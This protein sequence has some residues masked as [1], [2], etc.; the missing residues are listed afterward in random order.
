MIRRVVNG[1]HS[2]GTRKC[3]AVRD[4]VTKKV[5]MFYAVRDGKYRVCID[6]VGS[7]SNPY[8]LYTW[9]DLELIKQHP[10]ACFVLMRDI[11]VYYQARP[12]PLL[13]DV[14][15]TGILDGR[16][17]KLSSG[18]YYVAPEKAAVGINDPTVAL[19]DRLAKYAPH[20]YYG[21]IFAINEGI[22]TR[23]ICKH[24]P[25]FQKF[26]LA[27][28]EDKIYN[29]PGCVVG[30][31]RGIIDQVHLYVQHDTG[32]GSYYQGGI[33]Y[34]NVGTIQNCAVK[35][36]YKSGGRYNTF[37]AIHG[38]A[39]DNHALIKN[40]YVDNDDLS[41]DVSNEGI[42]VDYNAGT[43]DNC[44][45]SLYGPNRLIASYGPGTVTNSGDATKGYY[46][47][48]PDYKTKIY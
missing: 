20:D 13:W 37:G 16:G 47:Q 29:R 18:K 22:I 39:C 3:Y 7:I 38:V 5:A 30:L 10:S 36:G 9:E 21:G 25:T 6:R 46:N 27:G 4:G 2:A 48:L 19:S 34:D 8:K 45:L 33:T 1:G 42:V 23:L 14:P 35:T 28:D 44:G 32:D 31:N 15:F 41:W 11:D 17:H 24:Q 40:C 43:I 26:S 12:L